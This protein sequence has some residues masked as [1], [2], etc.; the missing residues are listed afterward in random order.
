MTLHELFI[1]HKVIY[2]LDQLERPVMQL[3]CEII[4]KSMA[5]ILLTNKVCFHHLQKIKY[6]FTMNVV[7]H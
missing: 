3:S 7:N 1:P 6:A 4:V 2:N 5:H